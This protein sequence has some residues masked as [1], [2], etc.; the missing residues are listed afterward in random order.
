[1][2]F[3]VL[4]LSSAET[5]PVPLEGESNVVP[6]GDV[7]SEDKETA[8]EQSPF[9]I[10]RP[11]PP[12]KLPG[13]I[14]RGSMVIHSAASEEERKLMEERREAFSKHTI[15][16]SL[17]EAFAELEPST[18]PVPLAEHPDW[19]I[20][21]RENYGVYA[22]LD[23]ERVQAFLEQNVIPVLSAPEHARIIALPE[24]GKFHATVEGI[25]RDGWV[26]DSVYAAHL[27][28]KSAAAGVFDIP[29][30]VQTAPGEVRNETAMPLGEMTRIARGMSNFAGSVPNR[31]FNIKKSLQEYVT[32][33]LIPPGETFSFADIFPE[34]IN[35]SNGWKLSLGIFGGNTLAPTP[36]GGICQ[37]ST[38]VYRAAVRAGLP[39]LE[40][41]NHSM[42]IDYYRQ[43]GE[44]LDATFFQGG[45]NLVFE[46]DTPGYLFVQA[47]SE[48][49]DV[50]VEFYGTL[51]RSVALDGPYRRH[52][53]PDDIRYPNGAELGHQDIAWRQRITRDDGTVEE[54]ILISRYRTEIPWNPP[55]KTTF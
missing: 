13:S 53:A 6:E 29:L 1:V 31:I 20:V 50:F 38:T 44:G 49:E 18:W 39:L 5:F 47:Y 43:Y 40:W 35:E 3:S 7:Q 19:I 27:I 45:K 33:I 28:T 37:T 25:A 4:P 17:P 42:Y 12:H 26:L 23:E 48:G 54:N 51:D 30:N 2:L 32:S 52:D 14:R 24:E 10:R 46:N 21:V 9:T 34:D 55:E 16:L 15:T 8:S 41:H 22:T 11:L 36:G